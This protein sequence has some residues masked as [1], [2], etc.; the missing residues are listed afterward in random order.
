MSLDVLLVDDHRIMRDN[1]KA[2]LASGIEFRVVGESANR[3][4]AVQFCQ[5][6]RP[7]IL[8]MDLGLAGLS[9]VDTI[10][11]I[12][13]LQGDCKIVILSSSEDENLV[14]SAFRAGARGF[15]LKEA[16]HKDL[17]DALRIIAE[18]GIYIS[19]QISDRL[20]RQMYSAQNLSPRD[21]QV[22]QLLASGKTKEIAKLLGPRV[23]KP[24]L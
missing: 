7:H 14:K 21:L 2:I 13:R 18:G 23:R 22:L 10:Q 19:P 16:S 6:L 20:A 1:I 17:V 3:L 4:D 8:L 11:E 9:A 15:I 5:R 12:L 24:K